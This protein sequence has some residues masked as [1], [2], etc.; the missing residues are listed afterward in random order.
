METKMEKCSTVIPETGEN[1][2]TYG[3]A[4]GPNHNVYNPNF[5]PNRSNSLGPATRTPTQFTPVV[6]SRNDPITK[7][8]PPDTFL[9]TQMEQRVP[10]SI[11]LNLSVPGDAIVGV[12]GRR[13]MPPTHVQFDFF[14]VIDG[15]R[16]GNGR[17]KRAVPRSPSVITTA[18][19]TETA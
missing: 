17:S 16:V 11:K 10:G 4:G 3:V 13:G 14:K 1:T 15:S 19:V 18:T 12:Y 6:L 9:M 2:R 8:V 5:S 7:S